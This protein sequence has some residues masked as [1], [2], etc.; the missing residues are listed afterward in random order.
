MSPL[1]LEVESKAHKREKAE[2]CFKDLTSVKAVTGSPHLGGFIGSKGKQREWVE[3]R[4]Q[5]RAHGALKLS[6]AAERC[7]Q[8]AR[9]TLQRFLQ[10]EWQFLQPVTGGPSNE[11]EVVEGVEGCSPMESRWLLRHP[12]WR[13]QLAW[14]LEARATTS[15][16]R[17]PG[18][19]AEPLQSVL[20]CQ[21]AQF[22]SLHASLS[23]D[24]SL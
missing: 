15:I 20:A 18:S 10:Q 22:Q 2:A 5:T 8:A 12:W 24:G 21:P 1:R 6:K 19:P 13:M 7:L 14:A 3:E 16:N 11:F 23:P 17:R 4:A 9:A